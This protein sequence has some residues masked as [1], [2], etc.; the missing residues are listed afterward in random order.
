LANTHNTAYIVYND[1]TD[2]DVSETAAASDGD[3]P[4]SFYSVE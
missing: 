4:K 1:A 2:N 3:Q